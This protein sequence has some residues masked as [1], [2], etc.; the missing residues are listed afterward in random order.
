MISHSH[1]C[2]KSATVISDICT[3]QFHIPHRQLLHDLFT[4]FLKNHFFEPSRRE[5][6]LEAF[7]FLLFLLK[8]VFLSNIFLL[9]S[10][11]EFNCFLR[12]RCSMEMWCLYDMGRESWDW[13]GSPSWERARVNSPEW[14][15][16]SSPVKMEPPQIV[17]LLLFLFLLFGTMW[18]GSV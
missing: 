14:G 12:S 16:G 4:I 7:F 5:Y 9:A 1:L 11:S 6:P 18:R 13:V 10:V 17:F 2:P 8:N 15:G 3:R